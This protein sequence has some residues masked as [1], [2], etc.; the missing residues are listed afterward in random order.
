MEDIYLLKIGR[1]FRL[2]K[3]SKVIVGRNYFENK[4]LEKATGYTK[5]IP[6]NCNGP[7]GLFRGDESFLSLAA[8][9]VASY[10]DGDLGIKI[11]LLISGEGKSFRIETSKKDKT[12]YRKYMVSL[13]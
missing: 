10:C 4:E 5:I 2:S 8:D 13:K 7:V 6:E 12:L 11:S 3:N 9:I 1:H